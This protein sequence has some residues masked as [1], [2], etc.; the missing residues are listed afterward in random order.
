MTGFNSGGMSAGGLNNS[1]SI[2]LRSHY[3][4]ELASNR[5]ESQHTE[6]CVFTLLG[7]SRLKPVD[8]TLS[9]LTESED[10][11]LEFKMATPPSASSSSGAAPPPGP[12]QLELIETNWTRKLDPKVRAFTWLH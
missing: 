10:D 12:C 4:G 1:V 3:A 7:C 5:V 9:D 6:R 11:Y 2:V 8:S